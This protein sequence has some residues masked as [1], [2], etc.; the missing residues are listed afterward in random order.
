[1]QSSKTAESDDQ[2]PPDYVV[3]TQ[4]CSSVTS[5]L[6][7]ISGEFKASHNQFSTQFV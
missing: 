1:M 5:S 4:S 3:C 7:Q 2:N 6:T